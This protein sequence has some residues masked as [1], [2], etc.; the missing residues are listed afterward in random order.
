MKVRAPSPWLV[1]GLAIAL[2]IVV[3]MVV[4]LLLGRPTPVFDLPPFLYGCTVIG[5]VPAVITTLALV[6]MRAPLRTQAEELEGAP[7]NTFTKVILFVMSVFVIVYC[8][9]LLAVLISGAL[10][11]DWSWI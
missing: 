6:F 1:V 11:A 3:A 5:C 10:G 8:L 4:P 7:T 9:V 2:F